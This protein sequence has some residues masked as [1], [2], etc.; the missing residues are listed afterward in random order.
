MMTDREEDR[1]EW[2]KKVKEESRKG[3]AEKERLR[4]M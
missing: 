1:Q 3:I 4:A 2:R